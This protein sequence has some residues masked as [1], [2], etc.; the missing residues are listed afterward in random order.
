MGEA[1][2]MLQITVEKD[3]T[4]DFC[5]ITEAVQSV[6]YGMRAHIR[7]G[8]GVFE[9]KLFC[10]KRDIYL[11]GSGAEQTLLR[12]ADG[13][14]HPHADGAPTGTFRSYTAFLGGGR[15]RVAR[16]TIENAAGDG[17]T[18][19]QSLAVYADARR[20][21]MEDV[22]LIGHQD[23][24]FCAPLPAHERM[25]RG[26][27]GP[28]ALAPR[29][30]TRQGYRRCYIQGDIDFI[31]GG[32]DAV[33]E[34]CELASRELGRAVNGYVAAPSGGPRRLGFV[35]LG[36]RFTGACAPGTVYLG[37]PW[38]PWGKATLIGCALGEHIRPEGWAAWEP[39]E[40]EQ[41]AAFAEFQCTGPGAASGAR[42][43]WAK[44]ITAGDAETI[45]M[46]SRTL[47]AQVSR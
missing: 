31:F 20:V 30:P 44:Q 26:F 27:Y 37:R 17:A 2:A 47:L 16:M 9:E 3:G 28:R 18:H 5:T 25:A 33:F 14:L 19:G 10:E 39:N 22:R 40:A 11:Q 41:H 23:T 32:A 1:G 12:W 38:R 4:G 42:V 21:Y 13:A 34:D 35:F 7:I 6:P 24:L 8:P 46:Q 43:P 36:C 29:V 45:A 15:V